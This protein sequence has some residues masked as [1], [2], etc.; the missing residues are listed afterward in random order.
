MTWIS[1]IGARTTIHFN[2]YSISFHATPRFSDGSSHSNFQISALI[3]WSRGGFMPICSVCMKWSCRR[4]LKCKNVGEEIQRGTYTLVFTS[5]DTCSVE[6]LQCSCKCNRLS[7][8]WKGVS[9]RN[10][11]CLWGAKL[12]IAR[13]T[14][15]TGVEGFHNHWL[16]L[17]ILICVSVCV[18]RY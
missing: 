5:L 6:T 7:A 1:R 2:T 11:L 16:A 17:A 9:A 3:T 4:D 15:G 14:L 8:E 12:W 10:R 18:C 13:P